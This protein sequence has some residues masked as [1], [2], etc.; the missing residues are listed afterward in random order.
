APGAA[1]EQDR[2]LDLG[3]GDLATLAYRRVWADV[4]VVQTRARADDRGPADR[5]AL[6]ARTR[7]DHDAAVDAAVHQLAFDALQ[8]RVQD[9]AIGLEH[10]IEAARVLPPAAH[11]VRLHAH[12]SV[13]EVLDRIGDLELPPRR[14][15]ARPR[16]RV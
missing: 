10:V 6:E 8:D 12:A 13:H 3:V 14:G 9:Q 11:D 16:G 2:V 4:A 7:L 15:R 1:L 5:R